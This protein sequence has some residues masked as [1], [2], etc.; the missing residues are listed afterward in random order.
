MLILY[1]WIFL[2]NLKGEILFL[3]SYVLNTLSYKY[4]I[5]LKS[6][7]NWLSETRGKNIT[8]SGGQF[9]CLKNAYF[10][11]WGIYLFVSLTI[12]Q[13]MYSAKGWTLPFRDILQWRRIITRFYIKQSTICLCITKKIL[14]VLYRP[15][16]D[17]SQM[18]TLFKFI[19]KLHRSLH[20]VFFARVNSHAK[21]TCNVR[22][23][24][25][26]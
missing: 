5:E 19:K 7:F 16:I 1:N 9:I 6:I 11:F 12:M 23:N 22:K 14:Y 24:L 2:Y 4:L 25:S 21:K 3:T 20:C 10:F 13:L 8:R 18:A 17:L 15:H 26:L